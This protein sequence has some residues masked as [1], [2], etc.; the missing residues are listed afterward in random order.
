MPVI[1]E[2]ILFYMYIGAF[3]IF[4]VNSSAWGATLL[5]ERSKFSSA[6]FPLF[7]FFRYRNAERNNGYL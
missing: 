5:L 7:F 3:Y 1:K 6:A 4:L 2:K